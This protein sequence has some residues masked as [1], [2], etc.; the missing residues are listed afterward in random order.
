[1]A[2]LRPGLDV[3]Q[4]THRLVAFIDG[5]SVEAVLYPSRVPPQRQLA[6]LDD[7]LAGFRSTGT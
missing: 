6:M 5:V 3:E 4:A 7:L 2:E 1:M